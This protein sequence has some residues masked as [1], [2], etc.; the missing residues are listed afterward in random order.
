[1]T[2]L[3]KII[4]IIILFTSC[5]DSELNKLRTQAKENDSLQNKLWHETVILLKNK[6]IYLLFIIITTSFVQKTP[7]CS[8]YGDNKRP[9][10]QYADSLKN[11]KQSFLTRATLIDIETFFK[12]GENEK[13]FNSSSY[14]SVTGYIILVKRGGSETCNCHSKSKSDLDTHIEIATK[15]N[16]TGKE[17]IVCEINRFN[18]DTTL[19]YK[20][21]QKL[22][23]K[24]VIITGYLFY[25]A[26]HK[27]NSQNSCTKCTDVWRGSCW[28]IHPVCKIVL[29]DK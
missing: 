2:K 17:C 15:Q 9:A 14:V 29:Q 1:M 26:E 28:E 24:Q 7:P 20:N 4:P 6:I 18:T 13:R 10:M 27:Q 21:I 12:P 3:F 11:R 16:A 23:G 8:I 5:V 19:T 22:K 25:D